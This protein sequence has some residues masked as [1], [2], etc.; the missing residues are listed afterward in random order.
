MASAGLPLS[1]AVGAYGHTA[2]LR[3]G[4]V[5]IAGVAPDF[6]PGDDMIAAFRSMVRSTAYDVCELAPTTYFIARAAGAPY[7]ALPI[8][9]MR[10]FHHGGLVCRAEAGI[11]EPTDLHGKRVGVRAYTVTSGVWSRGILA[12]SFGVDLGRIT[13]VV[14]DE[15]HVPALRLPANVVPA[16]PGRSLADMIGTG[17]IDAG[18]AGPAGIRDARP[19]GAHE[20]FDDPAGREAAW[21][22]RTGI[23]PIHGLVV[24]KESLLDAHAWLPGALFDAFSAARDG[25]V[26]RL[27]DGVGDSPDDRRYRA[28]IE[29]VGNPLPYGIAANRPAIEALLAYSERQGLIPHRPAVDAL[30]VDPRG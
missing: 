2:A 7:R 23:Y 27:S 17:E 1:I 10:R 8:F 29:V 20:L 18:L 19:V 14:D 9:L 12:D 5:A 28:L 25:Y 22:R 21:Y 6:A 4:K 30:F 26:R 11:R 13:W 24:V 15:D 3:E 16:P